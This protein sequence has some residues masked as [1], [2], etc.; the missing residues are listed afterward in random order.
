MLDLIDAIIISIP[1]ISALIAIT[2]AIKSNYL[3]NKFNDF[4]MDFL[5]DA[6]QDEQFQKNL[7]IVG[8]LVSQG[9][10][11]GLGIGSKGGKLKFT[12]ILMQV[13]AQFAQSLIEKNLPSASPAGSNMSGYPLLG[14][15]G[16]ING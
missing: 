2:W 5:N 7:Y 8:G 4:I 10:K 13:G 9:A 3:T 6:V 16:Q 15:D 11:A 12:D 1:S 14:K